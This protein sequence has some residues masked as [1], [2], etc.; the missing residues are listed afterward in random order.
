MYL[1]K[2]LT[3]INIGDIFLK[4]GTVGEREGSKIGV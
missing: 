3:D 2:K 4:S 1:Q